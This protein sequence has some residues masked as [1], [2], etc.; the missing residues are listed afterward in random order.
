MKI[1]IKTGLFLLAALGASGVSP[2]SAQLLAQDL[3]VASVG[4]AGAAQVAAQGHAVG[5]QAQAVNKAEND[6]LADISKLQ[7]GQQNPHAQE[8]AGSL[9]KI[10]TPQMAALA[11][12]SNSPPVLDAGKGKGGKDDLAGG[13]VP[14][15]VKGVIKRLNMATENV[16]LEDLNSAREAVAKLDIL[17]DIEKRLTDLAALRQEREEKSLATA[18]P[19]SALGMRGGPSLPASVPAPTPG[20]SSQQAA[21]PPVFTPPAAPIEVQRIS[22]SGGHYTALVKAGEG[23]PTLV[24]EGDKAP[25]GS[26][27][28]SITVRGVTFLKDKKSR[29]VQ[30]KDIAVV[31]NGR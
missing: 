9:P 25:D 21:P 20:Y 26:I 22:G 23:K 7:Q 3:A 17:I 28:E 11:L 27:V 2:A 6:T 29:T 30:V 4:A 1:A 5:A 10:E 24:H 16:T 15:S 19:A 18:L 8:S 14:D 12:P 31:Y 13:K